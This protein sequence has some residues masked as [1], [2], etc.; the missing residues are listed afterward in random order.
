MIIR[1][2]DTWTGPSLPQN[3][4]GAARRAARAWVANW[5]GLAV[6]LGI[7]VAVARG[8]AGLQTVWLDETA[9]LAGIGLGPM[10]VTRWLTGTPQAF[11][12][13]VPSDRMPP[14]SYYYHQMWT[15]VVGTSV[16]SLRWSGIVCGVGAVALTYATARRA[17]GPRAAMVA[18]A[19][20]GLAP[21]VIEKAVEI[22]AYPLYLLFA[23]AALY[24]TV[25]HVQAARGHL[26]L[27]LAAALAGA[28]LLTHLQ[29]LVFAIALL[30]AVAVH[31]RSE[32]RSLAPLIAGLGTVAAALLLVTPFI[33]HSLAVSRSGAP[34]AIAG[35]LASLHDLA[36]SLASNRINLDVWALVVLPPVGAL[37]VIA[38]A[39]TGRVVAG[40]SSSPVTRVLLW[41]VGFYLLGV[42]AECL[43]VTAF[44]PGLFHYNLPMVPTLALLF[45]S[46][47]AIPDTRRRRVALTGATIL[48]ACQAVGDVR[49]VG[50]GQRVAHGI[51]MRLVQRIERLGPDRVAVIHE[52][53]SNGADCQV[54]Y[55][56]AYFVG[57]S[58]NQWV[59]D[60]KARWFWQ[61]SDTRLT[62]PASLQTPHVIVVRIEAGD[63]F[64]S[65]ATAPTP[66]A[67]GLAAQAFDDSR[68]W[69]FVESFTYEAYFKMTAWVFDRVE[70]VRTDRK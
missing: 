31:H 21:A 14:L 37:F 39:V 18:A 34:F 46:I 41:L 42:V 60:E 30:L 28:T 35:N 32:R 7:F 53:G 4:T 47:V 61:Y 11:D 44:R 22:R 43:V 29:G 23:A 69:R 67:R 25:R 64:R 58:L 15:M 16:L 2:R 19:F 3:S 55:P 66:M 62:T 1:M 52:A 13:A 12:W 48:L 49:M 50:E 20:I 33:G 63:P 36:W 6:I 70:P 27:I 51:D 9:Q 65:T 17:Y 5:V 68:D 45:G 56:L 26:W 54:Y 24:A 38:A 59:Y 40:R 10:G 8:F 57:G